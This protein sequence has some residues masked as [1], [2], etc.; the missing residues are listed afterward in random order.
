MAKGR[1]G[2]CSWMRRAGR[3]RDLYD[4]STAYRSFLCQVPCTRLSSDDAPDDRFATWTTLLVT[5]SHIGCSRKHVRH[6]RQRTYTHTCRS[7][8][9]QTRFYIARRFPIRNAPH[10]RAYPATRSSKAATRIADRITHASASARS[11]IDPSGVS[12]GLAG[13]AHPTRGPSKYP[14]FLANI[15]VHRK[16]LQAGSMRVVHC[17]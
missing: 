14:V 7:L 12:L 6:P 16:P 8:P 9:E 5:A 1:N 3:R 17:P 10:A 4:S 15:C 2:P 13:N 11:T